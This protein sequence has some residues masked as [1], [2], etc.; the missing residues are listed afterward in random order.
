MH[1]VQE[2]LQAYILEQLKDDFNVVFGVLRDAIKMSNPAVAGMARSL[3]AKKFQKILE[4]RGLEKQIYD[5][6]FQEFLGLVKNDK[7][8]VKN[9]SQV[10]QQVL[11]YIDAQESLEE[12]KDWNYKYDEDGDKK[13]VLFL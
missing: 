1:E 7:L 8:N 12:N 5:I 9:E 4:Q 3:I 6:P 10:F 2:I 11:N 13:E